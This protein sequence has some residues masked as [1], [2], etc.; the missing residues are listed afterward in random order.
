[1][2]FEVRYARVKRLAKCSLCGEGPL[3]G[4]GRVHIYDTGLVL[5]GAFPKFGIPIGVA[6]F[7][8]IICEQTYRTI[9]YSKI[10]SHKT[11]IPL[12]RRHHKIIFSSASGKRGSIL[13]K[14]RR[15]SKRRNHEFTKILEEHRVAFAP[16]VGV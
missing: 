15:L 7:R 16:V 12:I 2:I 11:P 10:I 13:F 6:F 14:M 8:Q 1:M 9:P 4:K 3:A 5:E